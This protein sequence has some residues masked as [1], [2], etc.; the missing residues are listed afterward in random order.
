VKRN[1]EWF[2]I[3]V[4]D[5][6]ALW[7]TVVEERITGCEHRKPKKRETNRGGSMRGCMVVKLEE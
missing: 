6:E 4:Q 1:Q 2:D 3:A 5:M 7:F